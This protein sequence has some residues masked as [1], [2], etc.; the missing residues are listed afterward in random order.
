MSDYRLLCVDID[1]TLHNSAHQITPGVKKA[2]QQVVK[3]RNMTV[4]LTSGR[5]SS[6]LVLEQAEL[7]VNGPIISFGGAY[8][9][10]EGNVIF[11]R[12]ISCRTAASVLDYARERNL[13]AFI[14]RRE[15]WYAEQHGWWFDHEERITRVP[16]IAGSF[17]DLLASWEE[18]G[19]EPNKLLLMSRDTTALGD[20]YKG[21]SQVCGRDEAFL[22]LSSPRYLEIM[23]PHTDKGTGLTALARHRDID[24]S[25]VIAIGDYYND[26]GMFRDAGL[27]IAMGN[28]PDDVK[29]Q[30]DHVT[31]TCDEDGVAQ[32]LYDLGI[33]EK[34]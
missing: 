4:A 1:G 25:R 27:S 29:A 20:A 19:W 6:N 34:K 11:S 5:I 9:L 30:A 7:G 18:K 26:L 16:G 32:A 12:S 8:V 13:S 31:L 24:T 22:M 10:D 17:T 3:E 15:H 14:Y 28:A 21:L 33:I 2:L 23:P